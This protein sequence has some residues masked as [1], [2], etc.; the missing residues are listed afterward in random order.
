MIAEQ[1]G[2]EL[3]YIPGSKNIVADALTRLGLMPSLKSEPNKTVKDHPSLRLL[4]E[5]FAM[6]PVEEPTTLP[7][8][9]KR[10]K[11]AE[12]FA[13]TR[14]DVNELPATAFPISFK[15]LAQ[16]QQKD[17]ALQKKVTDKVPGYSIN[18]FHGGE[19]DRLLICKDKK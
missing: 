16:E 4:S 14:S 15:I 8:N 13:F 17:Q 11:L 18:S 7:A 3:H 19:K 10:G 12:V 9:L 1:Y 2:A 5:A 6:I